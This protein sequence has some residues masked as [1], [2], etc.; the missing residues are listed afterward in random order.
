MNLKTKSKKGSSMVTVLI[1]GLFL[2]L[3]GMAVLSLVIKNLVSSRHVYEQN[4]AFKAA[5]AG[6][7]KVM[8][9]INDETSPV[10]NF[11]FD[12]KI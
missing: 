8:T 12:G 7:E 11:P 3:A 9:K 6:I 10:Y 4:L 5:E 2:A 1:I